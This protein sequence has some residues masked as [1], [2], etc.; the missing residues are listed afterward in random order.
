MPRASRGRLRSDVGVVHVAPSP[1]LA[2]LEGLDDRVLDGIEVRA[3]VLVLRGV[4]AADMAAGQ[5]QAQMDPA[6]ARLQAV[7]AALRARRDLAN[8]AQVRIRFRHGVPR[9]SR[10]SGTSRC[11]CP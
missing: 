6:V 4:A 9:Y 5:T 1:V 10:L 11:P 3:R 7:L 8:L 2:R